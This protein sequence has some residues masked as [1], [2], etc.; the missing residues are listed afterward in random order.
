MQ[1]GRSYTYPYNNR[2]RSAQITISLVF[3]R[4]LRECLTLVMQTSGKY[5]GCQSFHSNTLN[6]SGQQPSHMH[7]YIN[8]TAAH[9]SLQHYLSLLSPNFKLFCFSLEPPQITFSYWQRSILPPTHNIT[10]IGIFCF[11]LFISNHNSILLKRVC[12]HFDK[13]NIIIAG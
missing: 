13:E 4:S 2:K 1:V 11:F 6:Q 7:T 5:L 12:P 3:T 8:R 10:A 9:L